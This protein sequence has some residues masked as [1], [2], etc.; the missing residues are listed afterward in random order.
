MLRRTEDV[1]SVDS[2]EGTRGGTTCRTTG[3]T[4]SVPRQQSDVSSVP[5]QYGRGFLNRIVRGA[6][7]A[8]LLGVAATTGFVGH[9]TDSTYRS[10][11]GP[12]V[13]DR[14]GIHLSANASGPWVPLGHTSKFDHATSCANAQQQFTVDHGDKPYRLILYCTPLEFNN[15]LAIETEDDAAIICPFLEKSA[16]N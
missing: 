9:L 15:G 4:S 14:V 8:T 5:R 16:E 6:A 11:E 10:L 1:C 7:L 13:G 3:T 2:A 12:F